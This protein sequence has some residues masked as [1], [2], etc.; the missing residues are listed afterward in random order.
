LTV[1]DSTLAFNIL[2][3]DRGASAVFDKVARSADKTSASLAK[4]GKISDEVAKAS[5]HLTKSR[6]AESNALDKVQIAEQRLAEV[7]GNSNS[8]ASQVLAAEK[9][10]AKARREAAAAGNVAQKAAKD[11][12]NALDHEGK[13]A[14]K[15]LGGS[16]RKWFTGDG[17]NIFKQ[18][19]E[20][21]G[22]V[23]GSG[24][25]GALKTPIL[26]PAIVAVV[27]AAVATVMP[28]VGAIAAGALATGF[29]AGLSALGVVF[30]AKSV[31]VKNAWNRVLA[32]MAADMKV[33]SQPFEKTLISMA[34]IAKRTFA[35]FKP[36]LGDAFKEIAPELTAFGDQ[37]SRA[38]ERLAPAIKPMADAFSNVLRTLGPAMQD[39]VGKVSQGLQS[40][41]KSVSANPGAL[42]D[43]IRGVGD[44]GK[45][46][47][48]GITILNN[49][50]GAFERLPGHVSLV[51]RVMNTLNAM[52]EA[53]IAPFLLLEKAME[54][55]G[56]KSKQMNQ[57]V[58]IS[59]D[60]AKLWTQGL[61]EAQAAAVGTGTAADVTATKAGKLAATFQRQWAATQKA[62]E[63]LTRMSGLLLTLSGAQIA[64]QQAVDDATAAVKENGRTHDINTAKGRA[65]KTALDQVAAS[66]NA[67][68]L[69]MRNASDGNLAAYKASAT[70]RQG[71]IKLAV[72]MGYS[73]PVAKAMAKSLIDIPNVTRE[74]RLKANKAD[75]DAKLAAA[76]KQLADKD[77]TKERRAQLNADIKRLVA[78][79]N[80]AQAKINSL[81]GKTVNIVTRYSSTGVNLTAPSS[82]GRRA[83]G[84]PVKKGQPYV[85]GEHRPELFVPKENGTIIPRVPRATRGTAFPAAG[86]ATTININVNGARDPRAT[87]DEVVRSLRQYIRIN[88]GD[89]QAVL[90]R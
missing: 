6:D 21:G 4:T 10:L 34:A 60:T 41:A 62:N 79:V 30:A 90:G 63:A 25:L 83:S 35:T 22:T 65:N 37:L 47:L 44:L 13:K 32:S 29:G 7:R 3:R 59:A 66:A 78:Q 89:V 58:T 73:I 52:V 38:F 55:V 80:A 84:G 88:G 49:I 68:M 53:A 11:L 61:T 50:N 9:N 46:M 74:A 23:F 64:Y 14:G 5:A 39:A 33:L 16:L 17:K 70:A 48:T 1:V 75:L 76:K 20:D 8:K 28:A 82:V 51:T 77:L 12:G 31:A 45:T 15:S 2:A 71:F 67:Q 57:E 86:G 87:A 27:G 19:G 42:A 18:V 36:A 54:A 40:L 43:L 26:G 56:L 85:V 69:A 24:L 81:Q 72:Q